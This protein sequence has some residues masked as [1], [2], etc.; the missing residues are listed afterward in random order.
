MA[1]AKMPNSRLQIRSPQLMGDIM[2]SKYTPFLYTLYTQQ[3]SYRTI[4]QNIGIFCTHFIYS[5]GT[6]CCHNSHYSNLISD[7]HFF[8]E[9]K[10]ILGPGN[11]YAS[12]HSNL[13]VSTHSACTCSLTLTHSSTSDIKPVHNAMGSEEITLSWLQ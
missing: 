13:N 11:S 9:M 3:C 1:T 6:V 2:V 12:Q 4:A 7:V 10:S 5:L 8:C